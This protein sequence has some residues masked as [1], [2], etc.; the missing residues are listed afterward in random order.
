MF[1]TFYRVTTTF[2]ALLDDQNTVMDTDGRL[3]HIRTAM[4]DTLRVI[5]HHASTRTWTDI[6]RANDAQ[7]LWYLRSE[8]MRMLSADLGEE[9]AKGQ[10]DVLTEMFRGLV[11]DSQ[12]PAAHHFRR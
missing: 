12:M 9:A 1:K 11:P 7:S 6:D 4:L 8:T 5:E 3:E 2:A 10:L